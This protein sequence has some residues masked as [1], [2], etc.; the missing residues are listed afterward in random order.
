[1]CSSF[2]LAIAAL[3]AHIPPDVFGDER[4]NARS[5]VEE[6]KFYG[7]EFRECVR[8]FA[9]NSLQKQQNGPG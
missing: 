4:T 7:E 2:V 9:A 5:G 1:L 6:R 3:R 8:P